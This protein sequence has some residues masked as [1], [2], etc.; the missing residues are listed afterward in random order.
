MRHEVIC[1]RQVEF[2][3]NTSNCPHKTVWEK[4]IY[5]K[6]PIEFYYGFAG[7]VYIMY[8]L[9]RKTPLMLCLVI[10]I[11]NRKKKKTAS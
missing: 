6:F 8:S 1:T 5:C 4:W 7:F 9:H 11:K 2:I 3:V 10:Q